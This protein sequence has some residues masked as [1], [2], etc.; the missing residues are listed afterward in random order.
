V[1]TQAIARLGW[2]ASL[3]LAC[4]FVLHAARATLASRWYYIARY[5]PAGRT[6]GERLDLCRRAH[7]LYPANHLMAAWAAREAYY[8]GDATLGAES[9]RWS[10][11]A[12]RLNPFSGDAAHV[13]AEVLA[14]SSPAAAIT[15]WEAHRE[16]CFWD[17]FSHWM[18]LDLYLRAGETDKAADVLYWLK[19]TPLHAQ[20]QALFR[21]RAR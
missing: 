17:P 8:A 13:R 19:D 21:S 15:L 9:H 5:A 11:I 20:A 10:E 7:A 2:A 18:M 4:F 14:P 1:K 6:L 16:R 12:F 3:A